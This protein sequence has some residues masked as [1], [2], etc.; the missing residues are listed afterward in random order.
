MVE[1]S[2]DVAEIEAELSTTA[3][4]VIALGEEPADVEEEE[5]ENSPCINIRL[6][7]FHIE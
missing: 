4:D 7:A 2:D 3:V 5:M 6:R 1:A